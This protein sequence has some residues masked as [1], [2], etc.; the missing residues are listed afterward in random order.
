MALIIAASSCSDRDRQLASDNI[1]CTVQVGKFILTLFTWS[2]AS[3]VSYYGHLLSSSEAGDSIQPENQQDLLRSLVCTYNRL[4]STDATLANPRTH[5][6]T[7]SV[8]SG[9]CSIKG[10]C[11]NVQIVCGIIGCQKIGS[12][13]T[14]LNCITPQIVCRYVRTYVS[15]TLRNVNLC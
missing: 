10:F 7:G 3:I 6:E 4:L 13:L 14:Q 2:N 1:D 5:Q 11:C 8:V 15:V 12:H 9:N